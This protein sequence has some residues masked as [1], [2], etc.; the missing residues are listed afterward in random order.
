MLHELTDALAARLLAAFPADRAY[1]PSDFAAAPMPRP[2][3]HFLTCR[4]Q[5]RVALEREAL[6]QK[7]SGWLDYDAPPVQQAA[8]QLEEALAQHARIAKRVWEPALRDAAG[9]VLLYLVRPV[10]ALVSFAFG[11]DDGALPADRILHRADYFAA[12]PYLR[13]AVSAYTRR[14]HLT[15]LDRTQLTA[16]LTRVDQRMTADY[17]ADAWL[18]LLAPLY[19][20]VALDSETGEAFEERSASE[21]G[22]PA[23]LLRTFFSAKDAAAPA[24]RLAEREA[25]AS[26][27]RE[28]LRRLLAAP[29]P[30][31][32]TSE[33]SAPE[34]AEPEAAAPPARDAPKKERSAK[35]PQPA[36]DD[37]PV[38]LWQ[39]FQG[40]PARSPQPTEQPPRETPSRETATAEARP[41]WQQFRPAQETADS[42]S[43][44]DAPADD[45]DLPSLD[46]LEADVLGSRADANRDRFVRTLFG[47]SE[48]DYA[49]V[50]QRLHGAG[51][52]RD[53]SQIIARDVF[54]AH[55][56]NIYSDPAVTFT[57]AV[58]ARFR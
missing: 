36:H 54:R 56:V 40:G 6:R 24:R 8:Q 43:A 7:R 34:P 3:A 4:L 23:G 28:T 30:E 16:L 58:E 12:Y 46:R 1:A 35:R 13:E 33:A 42:P 48:A 31:T 22:V 29:A 25:R 52:W 2:V 38:P 47:G 45:H 37:A 39:Q 17:D 9:R 26:V 27:D 53:A 21:E 5:E 32:P 19:E 55:Q 20:T 10:H 14:K 18:R 50:L 51:S 11:E 44:Q 15:R 57:N 41:L 49:R